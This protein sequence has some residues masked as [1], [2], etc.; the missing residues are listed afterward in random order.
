M[1]QPYI[2]PIATKSVAKEKPAE[3]VPLDGHTHAAMEPSAHVT[4]KID[5]RVRPH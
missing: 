5:A 4:G 1:A 3:T 2:G